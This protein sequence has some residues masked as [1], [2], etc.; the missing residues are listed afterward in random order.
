M[1]PDLKVEK[2]MGKFRKRVR[3]DD[4]RKGEV[5]YNAM[6]DKYLYKVEFPD[7]TMEQLES[8]IIA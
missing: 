6:H 3:Y 5:N 7:G 1:I 4:T 2:L 8:N